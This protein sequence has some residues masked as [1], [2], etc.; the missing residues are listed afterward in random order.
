MQINHI[1]TSRKGGAFLA[2]KSLHL[3]LID[4]GL[5]S[6]IYLRHLQS[7]GKVITGEHLINRSLTSVYSSKIVTALQANIVQ[8]GRELITTFGVTA[9]YEWSEI[10]L[11]SIIHIHSIYNLVN[12]SVLKEWVNQGRTLILQLH[13]E[14]FLT[15]GCHHDLGCIGFEKN[16]MKCPQV[17]RIFRPYV[18]KEKNSINWIL[19]Q[20]K[21]HMVAPS[22]YLFNK[23]LKLVP[24]DRLHLIPNVTTNTQAIDSFERTKIRN[25]L[26]LKES[27]FVL[28][29]CA[30]NLDS[31]YKNFNYFKV[32]VKEL[33][34]IW[35]DSLPNLKVMLVGD[36]GEKFQDDSLIRFSSSNES[37]VRAHIAAMD[38]LLVPS[39]IDNVPN[40]I[41]EALLEG[42]PVLASPVGGIPDLFEHLI[43]DFSLTGEPGLDS[44]RIIQM[45]GKYDR[46]SIKKKS[47]EKF[48]QK[49]II[50]SYL[51]LYKFLHERGIS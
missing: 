28:G 51:E 19:E 17:Q 30:A 38:L 14:R 4:E 24:R 42:T 45:T 16:C 39:Q 7:Q 5:D 49:I 6:R 47:R 50:N 20:P 41:I 12:S 2:A 25:S 37:E 43:E 27:D 26:K 44:K 32:I 21:V 33:R 29:F 9:P 3:G 40:V 8:S 11:G 1:V 31:P 35:I 48:N 15:G 23:A 13:D 18:S 46:D 22:N 34:K 36:G 10:Q